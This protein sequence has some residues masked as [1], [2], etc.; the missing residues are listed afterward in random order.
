MNKRVQRYSRRNNRQQGVIFWLLIFLLICIAVLAYMIAW[1]PAIGVLIYFAVRKDKNGHK[2]RNI[3]IT[4]AVLVTSF[5]FCIYS[6][7]S[8]TELESLQAMWPKREYD[9]AD[10]VEVSISG[11]PEGA[12]IDGLTMDGGGIAEM[13]YEDGVARVSFTGT[14]REAI[15][16]SSGDVESIPVTITVKDAAAE[17][18]AQ[19][20]A[21]QEEPAQEEATEEAT[22]V[23]EEQPTQATQ[24][25]TEQEEPVQEQEEQEEMVWI[26]A[27]GSK[28]HSDPTCSGMNN[29]TKVTKEEAESAGYEPCKRCY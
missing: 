19:E 17:Q 2:K 25:E 10:T 4:S 14:G 12:D 11:K 26:P 1:I 22:E 21:A 20:Q 6:L 7:S 16:F 24:G 13:T 3:I 8:P 23:A 18:A 9:I 28:Y 27:S 29:P 5:G 15:S